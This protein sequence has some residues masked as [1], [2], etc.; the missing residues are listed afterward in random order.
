[1]VSFL[2]YYN[3][4]K[5]KQM[6]KDSSISWPQII[7]SKEIEKKFKITGYPTNILI[8]PNGRDAILTTSLD[9]IFF[10]NNIH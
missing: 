1:M 6:I 9:A 5:A 8:M 7:L 10:E 2:S 4:G 3:I